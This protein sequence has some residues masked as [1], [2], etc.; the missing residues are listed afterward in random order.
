M[1]Y[2]SFTKEKKILEG[3]IHQDMRNLRISSSKKEYKI[4][5]DKINKNNKYVERKMI[6]TKSKKLQNLRLEHCKDFTSDVN[7]NEDKENN[8]RS[9]KKRNRWKI[10]NKRNRSSKVKI[11]KRKEKILIKEQ[12]LIDKLQNIDMP[13]EDRFK[14]YDIKTMI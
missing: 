5:Q 6:N 8:L 7:H 13:S 14:A 11:I 9:E 12:H 2:K 1:A 10:N 3:K 4:V